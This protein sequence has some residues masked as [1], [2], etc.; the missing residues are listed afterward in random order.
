[1]K[2]NQSFMSEFICKELVVGHHQYAVLSEINFKTEIDKSCNPHVIS[3][4]CS[5]SLNCVKEQMGFRITLQTANNKM[6]LISV[7]WQMLMNFS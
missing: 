6:A 2:I 3:T 5:F 1:M 4:I 7:L